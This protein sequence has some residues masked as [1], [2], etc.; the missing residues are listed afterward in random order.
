V[1]GRA[2]RREDAGA[3]GA[4]VS[5]ALGSAPEGVSGADADADATAVAR[6]RTHCACFIVGAREGAAE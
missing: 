2:A 3:R 4:G 6:H 5:P 1:R